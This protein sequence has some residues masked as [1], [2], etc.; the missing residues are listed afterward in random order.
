MVQV[1]ICESSLRQFD[2]PNHV[3]RGYTTP[4]DTGVFQINVDYHGQEA[5][6]L[7][8]DIYTLDGNIAFAKYLYQKNGLRDWSASEK[9][10]SR[11]GIES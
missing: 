5:K 6:D 3:L 1:A 11:L 4:A 7:G 9:C 10:L 8:F 2:A